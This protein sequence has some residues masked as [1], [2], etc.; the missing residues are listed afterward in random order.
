MGTSLCGL[1][2]AVS[3]R[4]S[5][6]APYQGDCSVFYPRQVFQFFN[7]SVYLSICLSV[8]YLYICSSDGKESACNAG[9]LGSIPGSGRSSGEGNGNPL[10]CSSL[11][12]STDRGA[13][14]ATVCG[15]TKSRTRLSDSHY[16]LYIYLF[17]LI[18]PF[19]M[20]DLSL[21]TRIKPMPP[22]VEA[23][24]L[25]HCISREVPQF[26]SLFLPSFIHLFKSMC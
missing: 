8:F 6:R 15:V 26:V 18:V 11:E 22:A 5:G 4:L 10:Q 1:S 7:L 12:N 21:L 24:S 16:Y 19:S 20:Q 9:D 13:W 23:W 14:R 17:I 3:P 2:P 25:N